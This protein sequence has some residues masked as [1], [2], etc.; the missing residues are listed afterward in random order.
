[1]QI[2]QSSYILSLFIHLLLFTVVLLWFSPAKKILPPVK[3]F[4]VIALT[5]KKVVR[6]SKIVKPAASSPIESNDSIPQESIPQ[7]SMK[8][9]TIPLP[10]PKIPSQD[11]MPLEDKKEPPVIQEIEPELSGEII[12][13][14]GDP[15]LMDNE[16]LIVMDDLSLDSL[17]IHEGENEKQISQEIYTIEFQ[18][19]DERRILN[20]PEILFDYT[21]PVL[22]TL[23]NCKISFMIT[24]E[25][26]VEDIQMIEPGTGSP[27]YN[28]IIEDLMAQLL[29]EPGREDRGI[30]FINFALISGN[31]NG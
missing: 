14:H 4:P 10:V 30:I 29:F 8:N 26:L 3:E 23:T 7:E 19:N 12:Y 22:S 11:S 5:F 6:E 13:S 31:N 1:M 18:N 27:T 25:G 2:K 16:P 28:D 20:Y 24:R 9:K 17:L 15:I 21:D